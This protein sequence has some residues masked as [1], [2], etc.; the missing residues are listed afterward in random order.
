MTDYEGSGLSGG[1][2]G[3]SNADLERRVKE[4]EAQLAAQQSTQRQGDVGSGAGSSAPT[5]GAAGAGAGGSTCGCDCG[6][7]GGRRCCRRH[8]RWLIGPLWMVIVLVAVFG[9]HCWRFVFM[10]WMWIVVAA[11]FLC[12]MLRRCGHCG[13]C[14][15]C[16]GKKNE[17]GK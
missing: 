2:E 1:N 9:S 16:C 12:P 5:D 13:H 7:G 8:G 3:A 17:G 14:G 4:L 15:C 11:V 6:C 10:P